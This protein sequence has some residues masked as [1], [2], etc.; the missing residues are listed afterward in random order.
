MNNKEEKII[1]K[2]LCMFKRFFAF[3]KSIK[4]DVTT[5]LL[6]SVIAILLGMCVDLGYM[7]KRSNTAKHHV[8]N[9]KNTCQHQKQYKK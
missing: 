4:F 6:F 9:A 5:F 8:D 3:L 1:Y 2:K 7:H